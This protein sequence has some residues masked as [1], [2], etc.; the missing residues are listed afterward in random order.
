[1]AEGMPAIISRLSP[2]EKH[3]DSRSRARRRIGL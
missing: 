2:S 3:L 1:M